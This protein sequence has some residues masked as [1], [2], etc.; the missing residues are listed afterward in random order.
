LQRGRRRRLLAGAKRGGRGKNEDKFSHGALAIL[1]TG[2]RCE[3]GF[4]QLPPMQRFWRTGRCQRSDRVIRTENS[5]PSV[6]YFL[7]PHLRRRDGIEWSPSILDL[8]APDRISGRKRRAVSV[9]L[10]F[11]GAAFMGTKFMTV[12]AYSIDAASPK[13]GPKGWVK[14]MSQ[15]DGAR[16]GS[17]APLT[18]PS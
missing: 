14:W 16:G 4:R 5:L 7:W 1:Q 6:P 17:G 8:T 9:G 13:P 12:S 11:M 3:S 15:V 2:S 18:P 10:K